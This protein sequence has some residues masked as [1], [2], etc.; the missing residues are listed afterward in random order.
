MR[1][2]GLVQHR[3]ARRHIGL[4]RE[5]LQQPGAEGMDGLHLEAARGIERLGEQ[6][7][8]A[9]ARSGCGRSFDMAWIESSSARSS[10]AVQA[11]SLS[12]TL[13]AMLAAAALVK[14]RQRILA[15]G[16]PPSNRRITRCAS[17]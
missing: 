4:E 5:L 12:N 2:G 16:V 9:G 17:T 6:P 3:E 11:A 10:S 15:G 1:F 13:V 7:A 14:V 8:G